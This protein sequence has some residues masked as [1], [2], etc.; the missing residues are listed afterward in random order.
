[1]EDAQ[2]MQRRVK[3]PVKKKILMNEAKKRCARS[4]MDG[5]SDGWWAKSWNAGDDG[6][7]TKS[8][9]DVNIVHVPFSA[10]A[11]SGDLIN[12]PQPELYCSQVFQARHPDV[13]T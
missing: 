13:L 1:M 5:R 10:V 3:L 2:Y 7:K 8:R 12:T 4:G 11:Y 6:G 9:N